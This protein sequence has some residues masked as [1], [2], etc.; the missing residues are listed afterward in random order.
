[1]T[2]KE[3]DDLCVETYFMQTLIKQILHGHEYTKIKRIASRCY[4]SWIKIWNWQTSNRPAPEM[5]LN[6]L[7]GL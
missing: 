2:F 3:N 1:M 4:R 5:H 6:F 7:L